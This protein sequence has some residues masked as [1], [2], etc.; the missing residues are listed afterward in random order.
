[1]PFADRGV[2]VDT[3]A[4]LALAV[5]EM[6]RLDQLQPDRAVERLIVAWYSFFVASG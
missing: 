5:I 2:P 1:M 6:K 4:E 3:R